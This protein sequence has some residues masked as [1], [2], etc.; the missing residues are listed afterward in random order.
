MEGLSYSLAVI[1]FAIVGSTILVPAE[2]KIANIIPLLLE[3]YV[4]VYHA[5]TNEP[6]PRAAQTGF[7]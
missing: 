7:Y 1:S 2:S 5:I 6:S 3:S 4:A